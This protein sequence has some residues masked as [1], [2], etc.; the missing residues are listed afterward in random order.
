MDIESFREY[1]L[2]LKGAHDKLPFQK[3]ST[4]YDRNI[5]VF[6]VITKWFCF[7]N[8]DNFDFCNLK[9]NPEESLMLQEQ[10]KGIT[11]GYH[12]NKKHW[13]SVYFNSDIPDTKIKELVDKSYNL[14]VKSLSAKERNI[15]NEEF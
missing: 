1:C 7:V 2:S 12:M 8:V 9:C 13:I 5:L 3:A 11:P 15:L 4:E 10:Y 6:S 14:V